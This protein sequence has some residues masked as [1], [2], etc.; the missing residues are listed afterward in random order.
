M[1]LNGYGRR[2]RMTDRK[3]LFLDIDDT[4]LTRDK[5]VTPENAL[6][7]RRALA[8][9]HLVVICTGRP[10]SGAIGLAEETGVAGPGCFLISYNGGQIYDCSSGKNIYRKTLRL[11]D[12]RLLFEEADALG[13]HIQA[14][15]DREM[16]VREV[17]R[18]ASGFRTGLCRNCRTG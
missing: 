8:A 9:G 16:L 7:I 14:Y 2:Q 15:S 12:V 11:E 3:I 4:L 5:K 18:A 17:N 1:H 10:H 13:L 6:A